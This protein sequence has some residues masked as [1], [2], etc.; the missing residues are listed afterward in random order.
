[1]IPKIRPCTSSSI[2]SQVDIDDPV[3][4]SLIILAADDRGSDPLVFSVDV[5][6]VLSPCDEGAHLAALDVA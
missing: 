6:W 2:L 4:L 1:M 3:L 5:S